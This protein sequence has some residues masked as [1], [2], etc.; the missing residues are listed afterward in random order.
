MNFRVILGTGHKKSIEML[1]ENGANVK[2]HDKW[3]MTPLHYIAIMD[4][5]KGANDDWTEE[6][7]LSNFEYIFGFLN[8]LMNQ[9]FYFSQNRICRDVDKSRC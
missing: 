2:C 8:K 1:I 9:N 6:D 3:N 7:S 5:T 4:F